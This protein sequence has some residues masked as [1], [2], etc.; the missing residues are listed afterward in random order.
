MLYVKRY[1][2]FVCYKW[3]YYLLIDKIYNEVN[4]NIKFSDK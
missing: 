2:Y 4:K 3:N 1:I